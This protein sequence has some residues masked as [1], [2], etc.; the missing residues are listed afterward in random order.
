VRF[1]AKAFSDALFAY[2]Q[3]PL[4]HPASAKLPEAFLKIGL[5]E[6]QLGASSEARA[7]FQELVTRYPQSAVAELARARL[8]AGDKP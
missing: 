3:L 8:D 7:A 1:E 2:R 5:C 6:E 4:R